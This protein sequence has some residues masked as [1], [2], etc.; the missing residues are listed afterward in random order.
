MLVLL[1]GLGET[2]VDSLEGLLGWRSAGIVAV[3]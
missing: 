2:Y 1:L 3:P